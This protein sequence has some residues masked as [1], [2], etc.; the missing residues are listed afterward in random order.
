L[1]E[2]YRPHFLVL[3]GIA[4]GVERESL[5]DVILADFIEYYEYMK[6]VDGHELIRREPHDQPSEYLRVDIARP[7]T[8]ENWLANVQD[9][10]RPA[11]PQVGNGIPRVRIENIAVGE[12]LL[13]DADSSFQKKVLER[14]GHCKAVDMESYGFLKAIFHARRSVHYNPMGLVIRGV[15]DLVN[16][17]ENDHMRIAWRPYAAKVAAAFAR[18]VI[19]QVVSSHPVERCCQ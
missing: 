15:S 14:L 8:Y 16:D 19:D 17:P 18:S 6:L 12:K 7:R 3:I 10:E 2:D 1:I 5:G 9:I 4:G 13:A 11:E